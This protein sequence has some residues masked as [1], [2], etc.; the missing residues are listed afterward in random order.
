MISIYII[1]SQWIIDQMQGEKTLSGFICPI[2]SSIQSQNMS[3]DHKINYHEVLKA[4]VTQ[5]DGYTIMNKRS[6]C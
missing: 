4:Q 1:V 3:Q 2:I 5:C 6:N